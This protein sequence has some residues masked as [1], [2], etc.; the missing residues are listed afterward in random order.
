M[1]ATPG[2]WFQRPWWRRIQ[3]RL[4][5]QVRKLPCH[6]V[7]CC[8]VLPVLHLALY[9]VYMSAKKAPVTVALDNKLKHVKAPLE[10]PPYWTLLQVS[11]AITGSHKVSQPLW[12]NSFCCLLAV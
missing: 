9:K 6:A 2:L 1:C 12:R 11:P 4:L 8:A 3:Q 7:L 10:T 5:L